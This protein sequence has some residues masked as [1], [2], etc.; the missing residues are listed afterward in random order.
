MDFVHFWL[1][2]LHKYNILMDSQWLKIYNLLLRS[3]CCIWKFLLELL[4]YT[5][6]KTCFIF[7]IYVNTLFIFTIQ[8]FNLFRKKWREMFHRCPLIDCHLQTFIFVVF[9][10]VTVKNNWFIFKCILFCGNFVTYFNYFKC[11]QNIYL[12][13]ICSNSVVAM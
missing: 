5:F 6:W 12:S 2:Y 8:K 1:T 4:H 13:I 7:K 3:H 10:V 11:L 9:F